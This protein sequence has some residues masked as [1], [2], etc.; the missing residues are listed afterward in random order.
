[1]NKQWTDKSFD[2]LYV[3]GIMALLVPTSIY[4]DWLLFHE[5]DECNALADRYEKCRTANGSA[6]DVSIG[7]FD[8]APDDAK[9]V[10]LVRVGKQAY[11]VNEEAM[12]DEIGICEF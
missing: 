7:K 1:M 9:C 4:I 3:L 10:F 12:K 2:F 8:A 11:W 6:V 5:W